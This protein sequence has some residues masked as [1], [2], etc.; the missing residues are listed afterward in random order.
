MSRKNK[1]KVTYKVT[2]PY[3]RITVE[4]DRKE[5]ESF[6]AM[7]EATGREVVSIEGL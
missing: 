6:I 1:V 4:I 3:G 7:L 2:Y 5:A